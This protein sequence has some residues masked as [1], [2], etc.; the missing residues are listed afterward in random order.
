MASSPT[1]MPSDGGRDDKRHAPA[2]LRNRDAIAAV[3]SE[4]LPASGTVLEVAS[5][6]GEHVVHFAA[7]FP[8]LDWQPSDPDPAGR[9]SIAAWCAEAALANIAPPLAF[10]A[11]AADWPLDRADA[12]LCINMVHISPWAATLGLLAGAA[13]LLAPGAPLI[14]YGPYIEPHVPTTGSNLAFDVSLRARDPAWGL[15]ELDD[16]KAAAAAAGLRFAERRAM[17]AN[18]LM[19]LFRRT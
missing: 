11:A 14:L 2:T 5:G 7:T 6:S 15:R 13:R 9:I 1:W 10:D 4:W 3:L 12:I 8:A 16:V 17:P 19:L 18:N